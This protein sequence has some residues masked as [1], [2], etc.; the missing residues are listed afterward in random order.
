MREIEDPE[1]D[2]KSLRGCLRLGEGLRLIRAAE[3]HRDTD[4]FVALILQN[5]SSDCGVD[6]PGNPNCNLHSNNQ[7]ER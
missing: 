1:R 3:R 6:A 2:S 5:Q 7:V 4:D